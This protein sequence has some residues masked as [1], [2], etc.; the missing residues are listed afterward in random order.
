MSHITKDLHVYFATNMHAIATFDV[1]YH[2]LTPKQVKLKTTTYKHN[3]NNE[4]E[5]K[6]PGMY[7]A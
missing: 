7:Y 1:L 2:I 5:K 3:Q 6:N 4:L